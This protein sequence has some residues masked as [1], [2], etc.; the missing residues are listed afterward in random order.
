L[1]TDHK[2]VVMLTNYLK[3]H[4][5]KQKIPKLLIKS[6]G[7]KVPGLPRSIK[8]ENITKFNIEIFH[9]YLSEWHKNVQLPVH[10]SKLSLTTIP[11]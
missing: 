4:K 3:H 8:N 10:L 11:V 6:I 9:N 2:F 5:N 1:K 7:L